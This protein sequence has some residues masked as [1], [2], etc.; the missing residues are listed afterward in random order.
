MYFV[1]SKVLLFFILPIWWI[2]AFIVIG[3]IAK[4]KRTKKRWF[5]AAAVI[6]YLFSIPLL[7]NA[8]QNAWDIRTPVNHK[9]YSCVIVLGGFSGEGGEDG[10]HF[11]DASD[12]F[13]QGLKLITTHQ[14][15]HILI[16][17]G[18]GMLSPGAFREGAYVKTQLE[19]LNIP[20]SLILIENNS[21]NTYE[22]AKFTK[23]ILDKSGLKGPYLLVT[24]AFHMRRS[25]MLFKHAGL[26]VDPYPCNFLTYTPQLLIG[27]L[28]PDANVLSRWEI[29]LKEVVG[30]VVNYFK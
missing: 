15:S 4:N 11:T 30:Y 17:G 26:E 12:R 29:Y 27:Y 20:D 18:S 28:L 24:S 5:I 8:F 3:L 2:I 14:A 21:K 25:L 23:V 16:S 10:G 9:K 22:N 13:I 1:L 7:M 19:K 6:F